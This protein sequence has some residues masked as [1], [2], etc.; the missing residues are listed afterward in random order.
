MTV[1][2]QN[3]VFLTLS[4]FLISIFLSASLLFMVQPMAGK[5]LLPLVGG[6]PS[7]WI[8][9][10]AFFQLSLLV[11]Y[12]LA[13]WFSKLTPRQHG[14][15]VVVLLGLGALFLPLHL[16]GI[17]VQQSSKAA[18]NVFILLTAA[19]AVPFIALSSVS[20]TLQ[21]LFHYTDATKGK[22]PYFLYAVSNF[23]SFLGLLGYPL[24]IEPFLTVSQQ[25][26]YW[27]YGYIV[28]I[29]G[30]LSASL[31]SRNTIE[32]KETTE[33]VAP[34]LKTGLYWIILAFI[35]SSLMVGVTNF[36][37]LEITPIPLFWVLPL[38]LYLV[39][40]IVAFSVKPEKYRNLLIHLHP[41]AA[42]GVVILFVFSVKLIS[43]S[44]LLL[45][46]VFF[47]IIAMMC[48]SQLA[49]ARPHPKFLTAFYLYVAIG[50]ALGGI[51]N[52]FIAPEVFSRLY[53]YPLVAALSLFFSPL[54]LKEFE[55]HSIMRFNLLF[56]AVT[57]I[58]LF[59]I[60]INIVNK[61]I[62]FKTRNF[63][64]PIAVAQEQ[65][66]YQGKTYNLRALKHGTTLHGLQL[67]EEE[68]K[69]SA[70]YSYY[71]ALKP[72]F[73]RDDIPNS[74]IGIIGLG[75]GTLLCYHAPDRYFTSFEIDSEIVAVA[76]E[77]FDFIKDCYHPENKIIVGDGRLELAKQDRNFDIL[78]MDAFSSD[79]IPAH[80]LTLEAFEEYFSKMNQNGIILVNISNRYFDLSRTVA[81]VVE[82][83]GYKTFHKYHDADG[84]VPWITPSHWLLVSKSPI[85]DWEQVIPGTDTK[86]WT[87]DYTHVLSTLKGFN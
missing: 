52:A 27:M 14:I 2:T 35:P 10:L 65:D 12:I 17:D 42:M 85:N 24:L 70:D 62:I 75:A 4:V 30:I 61:D 15:S 13:H 73:A 22:D 43:L 11:G 48:H 16:K 20:S 68:F 33:I 46:L 63:Y 49:A 34:K 81:K 38:A 5:M 40:Y 51:L 80:L 86:L 44:A 21:R 66:D 31:L 56:A 37:T 58:T 29:A 67:R 19:V 84:L 72:F 18:M 28:L 9:A 71:A 1:K 23:G 57:S 32:N 47:L 69:K 41:F 83:Y 8:V 26:H 79:A 59:I 55:K 82:K 50:G 36:V 87:D 74:S 60:S 64:G 39:T 78:I 77:Y 7:G 25:T 6:A 54:L 45:H 76:N 53:E 3:N